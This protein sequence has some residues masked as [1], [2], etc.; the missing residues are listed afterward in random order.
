[1][2]DYAQ[3]LLRLVVDSFGNVALHDQKVRVVDV[4]FDTQEEV[5]HAFLRLNFAVDVAFN[6]V[7]FDG[8]C[9]A[10]LLFFFE[11]S[12]REFAVA[13]VE[14]KRHG[15]FGDARISIL[16]YKLLHFLYANER[17]F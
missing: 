6:F 5:A 16:V 12:W 4:E 7:V 14:G 10:D 1:M 11:T 2:L 13:V 3:D 9:D 8:S 15:G 17:C